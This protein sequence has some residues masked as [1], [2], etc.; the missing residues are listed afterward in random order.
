MEILVAI[1]TIALL[2]VL[3]YVIRFIPPKKE[4]PKPKLTDEEKEK[5]EKAKEAFQN[6]MKYDEESALKRK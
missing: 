4:E 5:L 3:G 2:L 1:E 6:L